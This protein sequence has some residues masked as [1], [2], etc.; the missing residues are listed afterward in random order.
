MATTSTSS[1]SGSL[2]SAMGAGSGVDMASLAASLAQAQFQDRINRLSMQQETLQS[3]ISTA[4]TLKSQIS[5]LVSALGERV[6]VGDLSPTPAISNSSVATI[7]NSLSTRPA[8]N[9]SLEVFSLATAQTLSSPAY[10]SSTSTVGSGTLTLRFGTVAS[11]S[12]TED[13]A[14][15]AVNITIPAGAKL[16]DVVAKINSAGTGVTAYIAQSADGARL[17]LKGQDGA[18]NGFMLEASETAGDEGLATLAW[19]PSTGASNR[20][21]TSAGNAQY[22]LDGIAMTS[23]SNNLGQ[24]APGLSVTLKGTNAGNPAQIT[25]T[26]PSAAITSAMQDLTTALNEI[27]SSLNTALDPKT[28]D[29]ARD[30]GARALQRQLAALASTTIM[31]NAS[32]NSVK[33]LAD[34]GLAIQR[35]GTFTLDTSRLQSSLTRDPEGAAAMFTNGLYGIYATVNK[36]SRNA[37][38]AGNP[39]S[40]TGSVNRYTSLLSQVSKENA[41]IA[42]QQEALRA[43]LSSQLGAADSKISAYKS[44]LSYLQAQV[45]AWSQN[46]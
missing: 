29:L 20:L 16:S 33:T 30:D 40:L 41:K 37:T 10:A 39:G 32:S 5:Q 34:L 21:L 22:A 15:S 17:V 8:G 7:S 38:T 25:F 26:D 24:I 45:A 46:D 19:A 11:G 44:T 9:Y 1:L 2:I 27:M 3:K 35:D 43:R 18:T 13:T 42:D 36:I 4:G 14:R 12:F 28:G 31:P 23:A 6:R